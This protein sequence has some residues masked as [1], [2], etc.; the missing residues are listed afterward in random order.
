MSFKKTIINS[1]PTRDENCVYID[2]TTC[3]LEA[4]NV[5]TIMEHN[6]SLAFLSNPEGISLCS[7]NV[8]LDKVNVIMV[9]L[10]KKE[11]KTC[12]DDKLCNVVTHILVS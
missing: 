6:C 5:E 2:Y 10:N 12:R 11:F 9:A 7:R 4:I 8:T 1:L 3:V